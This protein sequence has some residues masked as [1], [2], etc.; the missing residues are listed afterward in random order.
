MKKTAPPPV[1]HRVWR[2]VFVDRFTEPDAGA[3]VVD[4]F[5]TLVRITYRVTRICLRAGDA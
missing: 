1:R 3:Y 5:G 4:D 2:W